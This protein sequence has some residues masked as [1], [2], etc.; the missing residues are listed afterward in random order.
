MNIVNKVVMIVIGVAGIG[1]ANSKFRSLPLSILF[2]RVVFFTMG[3]LAILGMFPETNTI[4][5]YWPL[6]G[7]EAWVHAIFAV[8]GAYYGFALTSKV[9]KQVPRGKADFHSPVH[10]V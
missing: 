9:P 3:A 10:N 5:G 1:A 6:F 4:S 7:A 8:V 2:S